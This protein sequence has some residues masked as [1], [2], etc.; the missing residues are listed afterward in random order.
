MFLFSF[1][2]FWGVG[3][4]RRQNFVK[5]PL[6]RKLCKQ[7]L[8]LLLVSHDHNL[9]ETCGSRIYFTQKERRDWALCLFRFVLALL[10]ALIQTR[11]IIQGQDFLFRKKVGLV[12]M[13]FR[14]VWR[15]NLSISSAQNQLDISIDF[16][17][18]LEKN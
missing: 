1:C 7:D 13:D 8:N 5:C 9:V 17:V 11:C 14:I 16:L 6:K 2:C 18:V 12:S 10:P 4:E 15:N 3:I